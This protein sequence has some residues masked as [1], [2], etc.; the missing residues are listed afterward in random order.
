MS[1]VVLIFGA[2]SCFYPAFV[3]EGNTVQA[4]IGASVVLWVA[5]A[6]VLMGIR[7]AAIIN[8][9]TTIAKLAPIALFI[10][11]VAVAFNMPKFSSDFWGCRRQIWPDQPHLSGP[12]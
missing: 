8:V 7:Q 2:L 5:H 1:Y 9:V 4:I 12:V 3:N 6:L 11:L 10:V